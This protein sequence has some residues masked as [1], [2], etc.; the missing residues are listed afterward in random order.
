M[1]AAVGGEGAVGSRGRPQ[2]ARN[3]SLLH[4]RRP[5]SPQ[6]RRRQRR[7]THGHFGQLGTRLPPVTQT[8]AMSLRRRAVLERW[9]MSTAARARRQHPLCVLLSTPHYHHPPNAARMC[10][11]RRQVARHA[12]S[13][14][15]CAP[16]THK[17][18][19]CPR[20]RVPCVGPRAAQ[21]G[22]VRDRASH[23]KHAWTQAWRDWPRPTARRVLV[24]ALLF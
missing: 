18:C 22:R 11:Q 2:R 3:V 6:A 20:D 16:G 1:P 7:T 5:R 9:C 13:A 8:C 10:P 23:D 19:V 15:V 14:L 4:A 24:V 12:A 17:R 21:R